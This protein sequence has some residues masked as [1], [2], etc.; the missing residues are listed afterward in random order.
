MRKRDENNLWNCPIS[1]CRKSSYKNAEG[2][3]EQEMEGEVVEK[4]EKAEKMT[5]VEQ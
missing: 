2:W 1:L 3:W 4:G 5:G